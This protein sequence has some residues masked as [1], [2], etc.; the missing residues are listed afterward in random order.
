M[1]I[2]NVNIKK[3]LLQGFTL[4]ELLI[5]VI[6]LSIL[7]AIVIPQFSASTDDAKTASAQS[8]LANLRSMIGLYYQQHGVYPG[9]GTAVSGDAC[10]GTKGTGDG[11]I[12]NAAQTF[13]DQ[14]TLYTNNA[15][16]ACSISDT[17]NHRFG[18]YYK[19]TT[20]P[21]DP[22]MDVATLTVIET[23]NLLMTADGTDGGWKYDRKTGKIIINHTS[24]D[25]L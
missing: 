20:L 10:T 21:S 1:S 11:L 9:N 24:Y 5:V 16:G 15:G 4:V 12:A 6:I 13:T 2:K 8:T 23:G 7:A 14:L 18:P 25:D 22:F 17:V 3:K 19:K